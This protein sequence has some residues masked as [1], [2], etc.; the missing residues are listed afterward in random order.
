MTKFAFWNRWL[1][2]AAVIITVF[3]VMM[4]L[5]SGTP[6]FD[7]VGRQI[8]SAF[9]SV[10]IADAGARQF[11]HWIYGVWGATIA[12]WGICLAYVARYPFSR[13]ERWSWNCVAVGLS[14]WF[15]L[16]TALSILHEVYFN[17]VFNLAVLLL[18]GLPVGFCRK[19]FA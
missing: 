11:Q 18:V 9:W 14:A 16:D 19:A 13:K 4:A 1:L 6:V 5:L 17:V 12:G 8:D 7:L 15:L 3:G 2:V 10:T